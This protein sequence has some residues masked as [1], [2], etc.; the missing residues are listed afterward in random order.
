MCGEI[1]DDIVDGAICSMCLM[2][3][4][5]THGYPVL[6]DECY[7]EMTPAERAGQQKAIYDRVDVADE[8]DD[9]PKPRTKRDH[10]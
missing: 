7:D 4:E 8:R 9:P 10:F 3:F 2:W 5:E 6:C 1:S